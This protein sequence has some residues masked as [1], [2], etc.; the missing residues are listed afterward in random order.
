MSDQSQDPALTASPGEYALRLEGVSKAFVGV[1][2]L[3]DVSFACR[4][5]EIHALVGENGAGKSTLIKVASG[6]L[7]PDSGTVWIRDTQLVRPSPLRARRLGLLT[8]YQDT[9]LVP[10]LTVAENVLL[11][12]HGRR[13]MGLHMHRAEIISLLAPFDLPFGID[14]RVSDL[15][16]GSRQLL[17]V[18]RALVHSPSVL[19]LDEPTAALDAQNIARLEALLHQALAKSIAIVYISHR[20]D[21]VR[22]IAK[23]VTVIRDGRIQG[24]YDAGSL[25]V[26]E[27]VSL[28]VGAQ[29]DLVFPPKR[30]QAA[31][32]AAAAT[33]DG[34]PAS[35]PSG[36]HGAPTDS[37]LRTRGLRGRGFGPV[38]VEVRRGEIVG[39]AGAEGNG[40]REF[41]RTLV[42]LRRGKGDVLLDGTPPSPPIETPA[43]ALANGI[44]FQSGD[45]A[46]SVFREL[47]VMANGSVGSLD[48]LGPVGLV[49]RSRQRDLFEPAARELAIVHASPDQPI[50]ELSGGNQQKTVLAR[51]VLAPARL[52]VIDE[53]TQGVDARSRL[54]IYRLVRQQAN[55][56]AAILV[57]SSDSAELAGLCDRVYVMSR[58]RI[59]RELSGAQLTEFA[60]V[61]AFVNATTAHASDDSV[62]AASGPAT[63]RRRLGRCVR[64]TWFPLVILA[65]LIVLVGAYSETQSSVFLGKSNLA[66]LFIV[67]LPLMLVA[68]GEQVAL[69]TGGVDISIG[70]AMTVSVILASALVTQTSLLGSVPGILICIA[71]GVGL[72]LI[73]AFVIL[74][75]RVHPIIATIATMGILEGVSILARPSPGGLV[76]TGLISVMSHQLG[77]LPVAFVVV[78]VIVILAEVWLR[79]TPA[80]LTL[81]AV[82]LADEASRRTGVRVRLICFSSYVICS[83][84]A[85]VAGLALAAQV[86]VGSNDV[87]STYTLTAFTA[88]FLGGA[89]LTGGR[90]SFVGTVL[91]ALLL[92]IMT[93]VVPLLNLPSATAQIV[94]GVITIVAVLAYSITRSAGSGRDTPRAPG[95]DGA[96]SGSG[97]DVDSRLLTVPAAASH[98]EGAP[99]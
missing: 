13:R 66:S 70:A 95:G 71:A 16:P 79:R 98:S 32:G 33:S 42:G 84:I 44:S 39:V 35:E 85:M 31:P 18:V 68:L 10:E 64:S 87:G 12:F 37:V 38:D 86:G 69:F 60:I 17:E 3:S 99:A 15:S 9:S 6:A 93:N 34:S 63:V 56:G 81:R 83:V 62:L 74:G 61:D 57:C 26:A 48:R 19:L 90:G 55:E 21:E 24:T 54:D 7:S 40:Q 27:I 88:C 76:G 75:L 91:G 97:E 1:K 8:A 41:V 36:D 14:A 89:L 25:E 5:G 72:G 45:R 4:P 77:F 82:G 94:T 50:S 11:S 49:M 59:V 65:L 96:L 23:H 28:M 58:G 30:G 46:E 29:T 20:L 78:V 51:P 67:T 52:L 43:A 22:R 73:N 2:A 80:G 47:S 53:P 92:G